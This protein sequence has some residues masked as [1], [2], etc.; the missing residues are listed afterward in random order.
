MLMLDKTEAEHL[1]DYLA[2]W[3]NE[4]P[5]KKIPAGLLRLMIETYI[6]GDAAADADFFG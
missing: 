1:A 2:E 4:V 6:E 5:L 3:I